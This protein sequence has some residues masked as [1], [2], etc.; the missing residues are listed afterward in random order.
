MNMLLA[1]FW[2][3][4]FHATSFALLGTLVYL[5]LRRWS[6]AAGALAAASSLVLMTFVSILAFCP[7]PR[8]GPSDSLER[9]RLAIAIAG[10]RQDSGGVVPVPATGPDPLAPK[11]IPIAG[12]IASGLP[13]AD[14]PTMAFALLQT[15][16]REWGKPATVKSRVSWS[17]SNWLALAM[18][19][20]VAFGLVRVASGLWAI[21]RLRERSEPLADHDLIDTVAVLRA[22]M[23]C[24][25]RVEVRTSAELATPATI[26]WKRILILLPE[27][28]HTWDDNER[29]AILAHEL[30]HVCRGDF[31]TGLLAQLSLAF[32]F[33]HPL[34]HWL[35]ARLR[36][37]QELAADAW[38]AKLSGGSL[39]YLTTLAQMAL[40]RDG[41][42]LSW[43]A[44]AFLPSRGTFVRRIEMLRNSK[45]VRH[46]WLSTRVRFL[47]VGF[48]ASLGVLIAGLRGPMTAPQAH[49]QAALVDKAAS[50]ADSNAGNKAFDLAYLPAETRMFVAMQPAA[51]LGRPEMA[52][53][54]KLLGNDS[55]LGKEFLLPLE[56]IDQLLIFWEGPPTNP[57]Q[58]RMSPG[59]I[60]HPSGHIVRSAKPQEW[61]KVLSRLALPVEEVQH[62]GQTYLRPTGQPV[63]QVP[64]S[65]YTPDD[66]T[67]VVAADD[68]LRVLIED[69]KEPKA[70]HPWDAAWS[71]AAKGQINA[72]LETRWLRRRLNQG[73]AGDQQNRGGMKLDTIA[74]LLEKVRAYALGINLDRE[75]TADVVATVGEADDVK[76]VTETIQALL[77]LG[78]N[79]VPSVMEHAAGGRFQE[80]NEWALD[81]LANLLEKAR[82]EATGQTVRLQTRASF[83]MANAARILSSIAISAQVESTHVRSMNNLK[84]IGLAFHNF[85]A[86]KNHL[87]PPVLHGGKSG[88]VPYS[89]RV[90]LLPFLEQQELYNSYNFDEPWDGPSNSKLLDKMPAVYAYPGVVGTSKT[91][92]AYFVFTG[93]LTM[94]G[95][96][97]KPSFVDI[98]DGTSNTILAVEAQREVPW[99]KPEDIPFDPELPLPQIGGFAPYG[100]TVLFGDGSVRSIK[101]TIG[102]AAMKALITRAGGE[103]ISSDS[104]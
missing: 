43:P 48:L 62:G 64:M 103:V 37:E 2:E 32:Q 3:G 44:R 90:A 83:D 89:W 8:W 27:D 45:S 67:A 41:Q 15:L 91:H 87:P 74:P 31:V 30:A 5:V 101:K 19:G 57:A 98:T 59:L 88:K 100:A 36:L 40:R 12:S 28:W 23:N 11:T 95:K 85:A 97:D 1:N 99:T 80:G 96:G 39:H 63:G 47:T 42:A 14:K 71:Q 84:Q 26:G 70:R 104:Y 86:A 75:L 53:V 69:R 77:T 102:P 49:A 38:S 9:L 73:L 21:R 13:A 61:T 72:V 82:I 54:L 33:Y 22:K 56:E 25:H 29:R 78:R 7:W 46:V 51:L 81:L 16:A 24:S 93:K 65:I 79:T 94:L 4:L 52:P 92:T 17:W 66:R 34:A 35:A 68:L 20:S 76:P 55:V 10:P 6:P 60:P 50:D 58:P 18:L